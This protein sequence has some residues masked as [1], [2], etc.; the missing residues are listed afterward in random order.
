M[1]ADADG[2]IRVDQVMRVIELLGK[3]HVEMAP[4]QINEIV[5][6]LQKEEMMEIESHLEKVLV[7]ETGESGGGTKKG[8]LKRKTAEEANSKQDQ[9][10]EELLRDGAKD[11]TEQEP[12]EH[13]KEMFAQ[14][15]DAAEEEPLQQQQQQQQQQ[16]GMKASDGAVEEVEV[17]RGTNDAGKRVGMRTSSEKPPINLK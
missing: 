8:Q 7:K 15:T 4:K 9:G 1:D 16:V 10:D 13:I 12:E 3:Q 6:M 2:V 11:L 5:D 17:G 14:S